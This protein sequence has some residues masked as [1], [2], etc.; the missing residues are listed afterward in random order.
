MPISSSFPSVRRLLSSQGKHLRNR[1]ELFVQVTRL[2]G[3][4]A[5]P[6]LS[7]YF[8]I[9]RKEEG[10]EKKIEEKKRIESNMRNKFHGYLI[11]SWIRDNSKLEYLVYD[12]SM[13]EGTKKG[14]G[15]IENRF[16]NEGWYFRRVERN[17]ITAGWNHVSVNRVYGTS[18]RI[19][20]MILGKNEE[21]IS[22]LP[23]STQNSSQNIF[24]FRSRKIV[25]LSLFEIDPILS[26]IIH[27]LDSPVLLRINLLQTHF[28]SRS[29]LRS[30][31][32]I[33]D[34]KIPFLSPL[35][36]P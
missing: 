4:K 34:T 11:L 19:G 3:P 10:E 14:G 1:F 6:L 27:Y 13:S 29:T 25:K 20:E 15:K 9:K 23:L 5:S 22:L 36:T 7:P 18:E 17:A 24:I 32:R 26:K 33:N 21:E 16:R 8:Q 12:G 35:N 30:S 28:Y 2:A 31:N